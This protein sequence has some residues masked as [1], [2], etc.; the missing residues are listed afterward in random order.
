LSK[1]GDVQYIL[2]HRAYNFQYFKE[3]MPI[4]ETIK[5]IPRNVTV[6]P[7]TDM[8]CITLPSEKK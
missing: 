6:N 3:K 8:Y 5:R 7:R 4:S 1:Q 2:T